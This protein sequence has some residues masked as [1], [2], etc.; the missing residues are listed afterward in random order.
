MNLPEYQHYYSNSAGN[1][2]L[3]KSYLAQAKSKK[4]VPTALESISKQSI[5][6]RNQCV[7]QLGCYSAVLVFGASGV[8]KKLN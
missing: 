3:H 4:N 7:A 1:F 6:L 8:R 2:A 5:A